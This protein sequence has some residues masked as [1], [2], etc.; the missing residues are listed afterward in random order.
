[1]E[2]HLK[3]VDENLSELAKSNI[4]FKLN[5]CVFFTQKVRYLGHI[6]HPGKLSIDE[7]TVNA[8]KEESS[9]LILR[10]LR[11]FLGLRNIYRRFS[12]G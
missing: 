1:M 3:H 12:R 11:S 6:I 2:S 8:L 5:K 7:M 10:E 4:T 9:P